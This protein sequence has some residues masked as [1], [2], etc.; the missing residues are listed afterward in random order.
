MM[1]PPVDRPDAFAA[2]DI[3]GDGIEELLVGGDYVH[4]LSVRDGEVHRRYLT[5]LVGVLKFVGPGGER[6]GVLAMAAG[7]LTGDG[8]ADLVVATT[9]GKLWVFSNHRQWGF[10]S[11]PL[12]SPYPV[13]AGQVWLHDQT[14]DGALDVLCATGN[15]LFFLPWQRRTFQLGEPVELSGPTGRIGPGGPGTY[16]GRPGF[17]AVSG[18]GVWFFPQG[19]L[20]GGRVLEETGPVFAVADL[21][22]DG[23]SELLLGEPRLPPLRVFWGT[24]SGYVREE[25]S[26]PH[27]AGWVLVG[28]LTGDRLAD[29]VVGRISPAGF[30]LFYNAGEG[31]FV[32]PFTFGVAV[33]A[34]GGLPPMAPKGV[35]LD[36]DGD[37][38]KDLVVEASPYHLSFFLSGARGRSLQ[39]IPGSFLLGTADVNEDRIPDL[40]STTAEGGVAALVGTGYGTFRTL[41]LVGLSERN[42]MPYLAAFGDV[43][44]DGV[45]ELVVFEFAEELGAYP[46][47]EKGRWVW[48]DSKARVTAWRVGDK[49]P[50]WSVPLGVDVRP[51]LFLYDLDGDGVKDGVT[52]VGDRVVGV[53]FDLAATT[54][55]WELRIKRIEVP[56]GGPVGP[57]ARVRLGSHEALAL[58]RLTEKAELF[59]LREGKLHNTEVA[60]AL[61]PLDLQAGDMDGDGNDDLV[62]VGW[63]AMEEEGEAKLAVYVAIL[64]GDGQGRFRPELF[65]IREWPPLAMPFPYGG[66][67]LADLDGD[68]DLDLACMRLPDREGN[69]GGIVVLPWEAGAFGK[70]AL[71]PGCVGTRL[72]ALDVDGDGLPELLSVQ[73]GIPAQLC[74]TSLEVGR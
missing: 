3:D 61:A 11:A 38:R 65:P 74:L 51:L 36:L 43:T 58:L 14:G 6:L 40:L 17:F 1:N 19:E 21:N 64:F 44:G 45:E 70:P 22:G 71:L 63:G 67:A 28:D 31:K 2:A 66:L 56:V 18:D 5:I 15:R 73:E 68:G 53:N 39:D 50:L 49:E 9:D 46:V 34:L 16:L 57:M 23:F 62:I 59:L 55:P 69:P 47:Y 12:G 42:R 13:F 41:P 24:P 72:L 26:L 7:D 30:S 25:L 10:Q 32:G 27:G 48:K 4:V 60:L 29:L 37:R 54:K 20:Q 8:L 35:L 52:A 33:P